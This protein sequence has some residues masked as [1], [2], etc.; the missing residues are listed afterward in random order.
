MTVDSEPQLSDPSDGGPHST[1]LLELRKVSKHFGGV[2]ALHE[3]DLTV[4]PGEVVALVGDNGAGK[5]TLVK[6]VSGVERPD[7]GEI[8]VRGQHARLD[9][10]RAAAEAGIRTIFQDL[11]LCDN[12][13][14]VQNLFLGQE[15]HGPVWSG[16]RVRRHVM[17][18]QARRVLES[19]SVKLR[20]LNTPV[21]AL[22][23]GQRQGI[24]ICRALISDPAVVILDEPTA[25]LGVSQ[26]GEVLDLIGRLR[27]QGRGVV[28]IS[29]DMRD[30]RQ[31]ADR[32]VVLRLGTRV[33]EYRR[34][35]YTPSEL[36]SAMTGAHE[37]SDD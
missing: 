13:D 6:L 16:R 21:V 10:P 4:H 15:R 24:A 36:V 30:V 31:I 12:L 37:P 33:A 5:S 22:S 7:T 17:E 29:H 14:A 34:G 32:V 23:G 19:L 20:S 2:R 28:V 9:S 1:P 27:E 26:R 11:S 18:E 3:V 8:R 25:A 35:G